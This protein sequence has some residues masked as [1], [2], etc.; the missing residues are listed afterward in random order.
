MPLRD[1]CWHLPTKTGIIDLL[2]LRSSLVIVRSNRSD[3]DSLSGLVDTGQLRPVID[4]VF[5]LNDSA[6]G[7]AHLETR[8]TCGKVVI[9]VAK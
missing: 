7:H 9:E 4:Q 8:R 5:S 6:N 2:V 3:L 1:G